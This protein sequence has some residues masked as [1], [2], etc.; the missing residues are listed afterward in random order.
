M[1]NLVPGIRSEMIG[2]A[3]K[4]HVE[5]WNVGVT[6]Q[7]LPVEREKPEERKRVRGF[8]ALLSKV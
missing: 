3:V 7:W 2:S 6:W 1:E 5:Y 4:P 8:Q